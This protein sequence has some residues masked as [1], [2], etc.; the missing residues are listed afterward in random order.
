MTL[1]PRLVVADA[2]AAIEYWTKA[3]G[4]EELE[5]HA[6]SAGAIVHAELAIGDA[7]F[8]AKDEDGGDR[9][10]TSL[11]GTAVLLGLAVEDVDALGERMVALGGA[12]VHPVADAEEGGRGGRIRDPFGHEWI[13]W[14]RRARADAA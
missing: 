9:A 5:R 6:D 14:Q 3:L 7:R 11:G 4:A 12:V 8:T 10:P 1:K 2:A 13:I